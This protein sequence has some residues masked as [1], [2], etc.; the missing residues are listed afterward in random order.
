MMT[1]DAAELY[2]E[3][4]TFKYGSTVQNPLRRFQQKSVQRQVTDLLGLKVLI[5]RLKTLVSPANNAYCGCQML[6]IT[7]TYC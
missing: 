7:S 4:P 1:S 3:Q 6:V 2:W 5:Q